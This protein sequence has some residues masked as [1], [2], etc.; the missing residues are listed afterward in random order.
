MAN[1]VR[2]FEVGLDSMPNS[3]KGDQASQ[4]DNSDVKSL[5]EHYAKLKN[6]I[7]VLILSYFNHFSRQYLNSDSFL[8]IPPALDRDLEKGVSSTT[9]KA[10]TWFV[11]SEAGVVACGDDK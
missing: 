2:K 6:Q 4:T 1:A 11:E 7:E 3:H 8:N 5:G 9:P 10:E